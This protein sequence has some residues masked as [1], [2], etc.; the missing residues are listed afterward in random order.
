MKTADYNDL[1]AGVEINVYQARGVS[2]KPGTWHAHVSLP[3]RWGNYF[4]GC[5]A[6]GRA[7]RNNGWGHWWTDVGHCETEDEARQKAC[8]VVGHVY[9]RRLAEALGPREIPATLIPA[10]RKVSL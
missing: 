9:G 8:S 7:L 5:E 10:E 1:V 3:D 4:E 6:A 2:G